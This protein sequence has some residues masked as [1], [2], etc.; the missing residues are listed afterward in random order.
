MLALLCRVVGQEK[1]QQDMKGTKAGS[2]WNPLRFSSAV[3]EVSREPERRCA[4]ATP[5]RW[6][7]T[8]GHAGQSITPKQMP[9]E[10]Q[11]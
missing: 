4:V 8:V 1:L 7:P 6:Q 3:L 2:R 10:K 5:A 9:T 11:V